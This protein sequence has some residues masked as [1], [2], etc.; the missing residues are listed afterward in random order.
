M[1][2]E[3]QLKPNTDKINKFANRVI[4]DLTKYTMKQAT[5]IC[6]QKEPGNVNT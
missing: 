1:I 2:K 4:I 5:V 6:I 3:R